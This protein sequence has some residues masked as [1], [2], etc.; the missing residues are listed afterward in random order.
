[1]LRAQDEFE[2]AFFIWEQGRLKNPRR[3]PQ[4]LDW[5]LFLLK[6]AAKVDP[7]EM[8][9]S[10]PGGDWHVRPSKGDAEFLMNL[11]LAHEWQD[12]ELLLR[13][14][15]E[16]GARP[17]ILTMP[18]NVPYYQR[19][20]VSKMARSQFLMRL[21]PLTQRY[22]VPLLD[23]AEHNQ[24]PRFLADHHDHLSVEGW[25]YY[26]RALDD[27]FHDRIEQSQAAR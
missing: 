15:R 16:T 11:K 26:N 23:F 24:D 19:L 20:G 3:L 12:F 1:M 14:L 25:M 6:A 22:A 10:E 13:T 27:F 8:R 18:L 4:A 7:D 17:L 9:A 21:R 5:E 2:S